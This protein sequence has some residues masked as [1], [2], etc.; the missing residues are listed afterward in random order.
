MF[1]KKNRAGGCG[2]GGGFAALLLLLNV[3]TFDV[4]RVLG[5]NLGSCGEVFSIGDIALF[6]A[7]I[8]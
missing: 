4:V 7:Q 2:F 5:R 6:V 3:V 1:L 8:P